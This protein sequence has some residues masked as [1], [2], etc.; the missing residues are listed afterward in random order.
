LGDDFVVLLLNDEY[1][2]VS[3]VNVNRLK[4]LSLTVT[5]LTLAYRSPDP[6][7]L[8]PDSLLLILTF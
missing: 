2:C 7:E 8:T 5:K 1:L 6:A 3:G 4:S